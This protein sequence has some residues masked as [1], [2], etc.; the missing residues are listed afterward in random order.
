VKLPPTGTVM[1]RSKFDALIKAGWTTRPASVEEA[2]PANRPRNAMVRQ[3]QMTP[4]ERKPLVF[5][6]PVQQ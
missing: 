5:T 4:D 6:K 1:S 3:V 2:W